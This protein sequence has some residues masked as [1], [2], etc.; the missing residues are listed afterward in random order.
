VFTE[1]E[2]QNSEILDVVL[3][4]PVNKIAQYKL[5]FVCKH[6]H[7]LVG[8]K[9][10]YDNK[11]ENERR[12]IDFMAIESK[13]VKKRCI[14]HD[15]PKCFCESAIYDVENSLVE[16]IFQNVGRAR[17]GCI[18]HQLRFYRCKKLRHFMDA[19]GGIEEKDLIYLLFLLV[20][21]DDVKKIFRFRE[22]DK[23]VQLCD[24][25]VERVRKNVRRFFHKHFS[26]K[27]LRYDHKFEE[28]GELFDYFLNRPG[29]EN[30]NGL[31]RPFFSSYDDECSIDDD[32]QEMDFIASTTFPGIDFTE[33]VVIEKYDLYRCCGHDYNIDDNYEFDK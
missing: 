17:V 1:Y 6:Y 13:M 8:K 22:K 15:Q 7:N 21:I 29:Y 26:K 9:F 16:R 32:I 25:Y 3:N 23:I 5:A 20:P 19:I 4:T 2:E 27:Q 11:K 31:F 24:H 12:Q 33:V 18:I 30:H 10:F 28:G 14:F